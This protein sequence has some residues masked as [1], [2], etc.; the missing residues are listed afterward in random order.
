[1]EGEGLTLVLRSITLRGTLRNEKLITTHMR[2]HGGKMAIGEI[3]ITP[4]PT[5]PQGCPRR[6]II[7]LVPG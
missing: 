3:R 4:C 5:P 1:M 2:E 7:L 6:P